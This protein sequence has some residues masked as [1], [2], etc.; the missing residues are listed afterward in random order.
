MFMY[1]RGPMYEWLHHQRPDDDCGQGSPIQH[2]A[3]HGLLGLDFLAVH[4]VTAWAA[5]RARLGFGPTL[6]EHVTY[7]AGAHSTSD[8]PSRYRPRDDYEF[9]PLGDPVERAV[10]MMALEVSALE[11]SGWRESQ[12]S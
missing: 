2:A 1:R 9:W 3:R 7:R 10:L 6:I 12:P 5:E 8:D 4:A 11:G